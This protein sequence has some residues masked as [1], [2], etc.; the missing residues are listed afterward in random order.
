MWNEIKGNEMKWYEMKWSE[1]K[2]KRIERKWNVVEVKWNVKGPPGPF[3]IRRSHPL[4]AER[5]RNGGP[6]FS[7]FFWWV[8][9]PRLR[10]R[11]HPLLAERSRNGGPFFSS[12]FWWVLGPSLAL[13]SLHVGTFLGPKSTTFLDMICGHFFPVFRK[14]FPSIL[15]HKRAQFWDEKRSV[16]ELHDFQESWFYCSKTQVFEVPS[17][18]KLFKSKTES[19]ARR[20]CVF[21]SIFDNFRT[22]LW[23]LLGVFWEVFWL[24]F[25]DCFLYNFFDVFSTVLGSKRVHGGG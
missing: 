12:F 23:S 19:D 25:S 20:E 5:S 15:E 21:H 10:R 3:F 6:F 18:P 13:I 7:S 8:L 14:S 9:G 16:R 11:S 24:F 1:V 2:W 17:P 4:L 22:S